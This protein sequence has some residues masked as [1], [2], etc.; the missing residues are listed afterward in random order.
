MAGKGK[1]PVLV[2]VQLT[3]GND[4]MNTVIPFTNPHYYDS[5]KKVVIPQDEVLPIDDT[6]AFHSVMAPVKELYDEGKVAIV[7]GIG[8]PTPAGLTF[9]PWTYGTLVNQR[10]WP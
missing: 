6:L 9:A 3:G 1:P 7:Q 4:F 10:R 5:R 2:V 8:Y